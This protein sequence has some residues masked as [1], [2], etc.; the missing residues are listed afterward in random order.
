MSLG[1]ALFRPIRVIYK[2][3]LRNSKYESWRGLRMK[4]AIHFSQ[5]W[6]LGLKRYKATLLSKDVLW[7]KNGVYSL[8]SALSVRALMWYSRSCSTTSS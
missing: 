8:T 1:Q 4:N 5:N 7:I 6:N 2:S 3:M